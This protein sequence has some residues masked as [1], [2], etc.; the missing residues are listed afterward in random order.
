MKAAQQEILKPGTLTKLCHNM[1][2]VSTSSLPSIVN[3][4]NSEVFSAMFESMYRTHICLRNEVL[5]Q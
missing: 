1:G 3:F 5:I 2:E 4:F